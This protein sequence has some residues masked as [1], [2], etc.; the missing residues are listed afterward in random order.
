MYI[1]IK[2]VKEMGKESSDGNHYLT[3]ADQ[4]PASS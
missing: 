4:C 2:V 3:Q 1:I